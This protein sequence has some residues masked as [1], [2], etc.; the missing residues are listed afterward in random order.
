MPYT[1]TLNAGDAVL[2]ATTICFAASITIPVLSK[3]PLAAN[4][5]SYSRY[6]VKP[7]VA[8]DAN[9]SLTL[10]ADAPLLQI[11]TVTTENVLEGQV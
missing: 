9:A 7:G 1:T 6:S 3:T 5:V 2:L 10:I 11:D 8:D 4:D